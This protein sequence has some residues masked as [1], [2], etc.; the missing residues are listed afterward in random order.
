M[1][2]IEAANALSLPAFQDDYLP[3]DSPQ[4]IFTNT[5]SG[6]TY[7]ISL[8]TPSTVTPT[9]FDSCFHLVESTS[10]CAYAASSIGWSPAKKRKEMRLPDLRYLLVRSSDDRDN[11]VKA[12]L[13]FM[14]TYEDGHEVVY[15][16]EIHVSPSLRGCGLGKHLMR[17]MEVVGTRVGIEK[18]MLTVF[19]ANDWAIEFYANLG[20]RE[21]EYSPKPRKLRGGKLKM[22]DYVILSRGLKQG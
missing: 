2:R 7:S 1:P 8:Q 12:F 3:N 20:Y 4:L 15:C 5:R 13:S 10:S 14:L 16:Y 17:T 22:A 21:D 6:T 19:M 9:D 11:A 18:A